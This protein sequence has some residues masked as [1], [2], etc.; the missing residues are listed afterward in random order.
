MP[1][2]SVGVSNNFGLLCPRKWGAFP[3]TEFQLY[4]FPHK[5]ALLLLKLPNKINIFRSPLSAHILEFPN[6]GTTFG[7]TMWRCRIGGNGFISIKIAG[8]SSTDV[9]ILTITTHDN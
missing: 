6:V 4:I 2:G 5:Y 7:L 1:I 8:L 9:Y 3:N